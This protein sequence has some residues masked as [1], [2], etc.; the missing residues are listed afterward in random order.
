MHHA[1][2]IGK[3]IFHPSKPKVFVLLHRLWPGQST[4]YTIA[5]TSVVSFLLFLS[6]KDASLLIEFPASIHVVQIQQ[7]R[8]LKQC[9]Y[10]I[11]CAEKFHRRISKP[12][13][14]L[15]HHKISPQTFIFDLQNLPSFF[16]SLSEDRQPP[17]RGPLPPP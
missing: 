10:H 14:H 8:R 7:R 9:Y 11:N 1:K 3:S 13:S 2:R 16:V 4:N 6:K 15:S 5:T 17:T 12:L